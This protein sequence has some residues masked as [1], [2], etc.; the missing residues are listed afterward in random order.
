MVNKV[1]EFASGK[2]VFNKVSGRSHADFPAATDQIT[3]TILNF[4]DS[5]LGVSR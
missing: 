5:K 1:N 2:A 4:L 3:I